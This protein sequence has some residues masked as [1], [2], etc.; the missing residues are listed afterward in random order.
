MR[1]RDG[2]TI[3]ILGGGQLGRMTALAAA[4]LGFRVH[5]FTP[6]ND[7]PGAQVAPRVARAEY[8][9]V[10]ALTDFARHVDVVT[11]E[12]ENI[13]VLAPRTLAEHVAVYPS[14][15]V[16]EICQDRELEKRAITAAGIAVAPWELVT[17]R[18]T[19]QDAVERLGRPSVLKTARMGY[20]GKGQVKIDPTAD[21]D[22]AWAHTGTRCVLEKFVDFACEI[23]VIAARGIHGEISTFPVALNEHRHHILHRTTVPSGLG[24]SIERQA[25]EIAATLATTLDVVGLLAV[26]MFVTREGGLIVN[27][28]APRPHNSGHWSQD[29]CET[30]QFEQL[31]RAITG[32]PL[33][34]TSVL[35]PCVMTNLIGDEVMQAEALLNEP[36]TRLHLYGK[37]EARPGRK[38][39]HYNRLGR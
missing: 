25:R 35:R 29:A 20:D 38:M 3:G 33:G 26:E 18:Q 13:D 34:G 16:L 2:A 32:R 15:R 39:G 31:V 23:S 9:D 21:L 8:L 4:R 37:T 28:L 6:E 10:D 17:S 36:L 27:E 22:A 19:L 11:F 14:P 7:A 30:D 12:F 1:L 5:V 24:D